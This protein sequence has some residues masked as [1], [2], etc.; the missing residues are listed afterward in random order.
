MISPHG[1]TEIAETIP[2]SL[3][4]MGGLHPR[5]S[6]WSLCL[7]GEHSCQTKPICGLRIQEG[8]RPP[9]GLAWAGCTNKPNWTES[10]MRNK[11]NLARLAQ[12]TCERKMRNKP[13]FR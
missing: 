10:I 6:P 4:E 5:G 7:C 12:V 1:G 13:N 9:Y 3:Q 11:P 8:L 2:S